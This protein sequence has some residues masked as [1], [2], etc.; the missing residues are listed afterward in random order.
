[1]IPVQELRIGN[2]VEYKSFGDFDYQTVESISKEGINLSW[3]PECIVWIEPDE[4][5]PIPLT[6]EILEKCGFRE[7]GPFSPWLTLGSFSWSDPAGISYE[8]DEE[9]AMLD[10]IK[11]LHQ[12]QN[13]YYAVTGEE[14]TITL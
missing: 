10:H 4:L 5:H 6:P 12:L 11:Y 14:L 13:L 1:M 7:Y 8:I 3:F 2:W 9:S